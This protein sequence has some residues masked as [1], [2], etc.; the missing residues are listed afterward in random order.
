MQHSGELFDI[1]LIVWGI[2]FLI[3]LIF[4]SSMP[5]WLYNAMSRWSTKSQQN[6]C[7]YLSIIN[8]QLSVRAEK[9]SFLTGLRE[10]SKF[11]QG[12]AMALPCSAV[13]WEVTPSAPSKRVTKSGMT[14]RQAEWES[15][16]PFQDEHSI[17]PVLGGYFGQYAIRLMFHKYYAMGKRSQTR[18]KL[19]QK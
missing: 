4:S 7:Q 16:L 8:D 18:C 9:Y 1:K 14:R 19:K 11:S 17:K 12:W 6:W 3:N 15:Y 10:G 13:L 2:G 5:N